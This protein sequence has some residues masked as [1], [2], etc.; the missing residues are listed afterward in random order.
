MQIQQDSSDN[1]RGRLAGLELARNPP[2]PSGCWLLPI[3][4]VAC[5]LDGRP[6]VCP[7]GPSEFR[8]RGTQ[9]L[10]GPGE[11]PSSLIDSCEGSDAR[12]RRMGG[13]IE[14]CLVSEVTGSADQFWSLQ[15]VR[16]CPLPL[17]GFSSCNT[18]ILQVQVFEQCPL[19]GH[20]CSSLANSAQKS[21]GS[22]LNGSQGNDLILLF[23][24]P[25]HFNA[26]GIQAT[27]ANCHAQRDADEVGIVEFH[28]CRLISVIV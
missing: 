28:P 15:S 10:N 13:S 11:K 3:P 19:E 27:F 22:L 5:S 12:A 25:F 6:G 1:H 14:T 20:A 17:A 21:F 16:I 23:L 2:A 7:V 9:R 4:H 18:I 24:A 26:S 8:S